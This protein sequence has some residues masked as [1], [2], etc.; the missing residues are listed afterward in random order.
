MENGTIHSLSI[1]KTPLGTVMKLA[2]PAIIEQLVLTLM[3]Y[4][5]TAMVGR[6]VQG[7][8]STAA[9]GVCS[10]TIWFING[11]LSAVAIGLAV[12]VA[13]RC[14]A[15]DAA[16]ARDVI[17]Q[18]VLCIPVVGS[19]FALVMLG[20]SFGM[21]VWMNATE[22]IIVP[23]GWYMRILG[24][25]MPF[26][27]SVSLFSAVLRNTGDM[28]TPMICN[29]AANFVNVVL[30]YFLIYPT[31]A[32]TL[33]GNEYTVVGAG[34]GV[35]GAAVATAL[36]QMTAGIALFSRVM[37]RRSPLR[38]GKDTKFRFRRDILLAAARLGLPVFLQRA[39]ISGGQ[40]A[41]TGMISSLHSNIALSANSLAI[42][43]EG[44]SYLPADGF[45]EAAGALVG[46]SMGAN[47]PDLAKKFG[48]LTLALGVCSMFV[49]GTLLF[50][51]S[52]RLI[53]L[54]IEDAD[55][56]ALGGKMLRIVAASEPF[57]AASIVLTGVFRGA[58]DTKFG[59]ILG[60]VCMWG[61]RIVAAY[62][63]VPRFG[64]AGAWYGMVMDLVAR[65]ILCTVHFFRG[66]FLRAYRPLPPTEE[67]TSAE[68]S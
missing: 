17:A 29:I 57:F 58:D 5:D 32:V 27:L 64:L 6:D 41:I 51:F 45:A 50:V 56:I 13:H 18:A 20:L 10:S 36:S 43:A 28:K 67:K 37:F 14:G 24:F 26:G 9:I 54:F 11:A 34:L 23:A 48:K 52:D 59:M 38:P 21:P 62:F 12:Q 15:N 60:I 35:I 66:R 55:V 33:F 7:L 22:D 25:A 4:V 8:V 2:L 19:F 40:I 39:C 3:T 1:G 49:T 30:N 68:E 61:I 16:G 31:H 53:S 63:L 47:R 65:G 42:T 44:L 46:Q